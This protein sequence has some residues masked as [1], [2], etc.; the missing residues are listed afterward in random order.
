MGTHLPRRSGNES[1]SVR[2]RSAIEGEIVSCAV[3]GEWNPQL[4]RETASQLSICLASHPTGLIIDLSLLNDPDAES[5]HIWMSARTAASL[6]EPPVHATLCVPAEQLLAHR[7]Q[8]LRT[9]RFLPIY[10]TTEQAR[11]ALNYR[12]ISSDRLVMRH[13]SGPE[14][15]GIARKLLAEACGQLQKPH[16]L[17]SAQLVAT[18]LITN[19]TQTNTDITVTVA[20]RAHGLRLTVSDHDPH[21][22]APPMSPPRADEAGHGLQVVQAVA[23]AWGAIAT[24]DG[25]TMW[26]IIDREVL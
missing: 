17:R 12:I 15:P 5:T 9:G 16:L 18:E 4:E 14:T 8:E 22:P 7:L 25:K 3:C 2:L 23:A 24:E 21:L 26:A 19:A 11:V 20:P 10:P 1:P 13:T 6:M